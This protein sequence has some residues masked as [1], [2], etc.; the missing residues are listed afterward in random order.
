[1][2]DFK[3]TNFLGCDVSILRCFVRYSSMSSMEAANQS[4]IPPA[5]W[6]APCAW[7]KRSAANTDQPPLNFRGDSISPAKPTSVIFH[8]PRR[9]PRLSGPGR[10]EKCRGQGAATQTVRMV[11]K[12]AATAPSAWARVSGPQFFK[13]H[14]HCH[15]KQARTPFPTFPLITSLPCARI[16]LRLATHE[17]AAMT[18]PL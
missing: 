8:R 2:C 3:D 13:R 4:V 17:A 5:S 9:Q 10:P 11:G 1:M 12:E 18:K 6:S 7:F 14:A 16:C 15:N